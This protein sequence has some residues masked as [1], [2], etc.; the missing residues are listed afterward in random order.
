MTKYITTGKVYWNVL[1]KELQGM[2]IRPD[3]IVLR[4]DE[5]L[6]LGLDA[7]KPELTEWETFW[8]PTPA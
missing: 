5:P 7:P 3:I 4:S 2:G 6:G 8:V 1:N